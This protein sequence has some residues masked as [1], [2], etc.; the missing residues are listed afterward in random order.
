MYKWSVDIILK[1][2]GVIL[3]CIYDGPERD[4]TSVM[5]KLF[6]GKLANEWVGLSCNNGK[7]NCFVCV[8]EI[9]SVDI[10]E[11]KV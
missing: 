2:S 10:Y 7:S 6:R 1:G 4:T 9:A 8:G 3:S 11:R 5:E